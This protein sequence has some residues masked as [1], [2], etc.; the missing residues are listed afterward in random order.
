[1]SSTGT[2][3]IP[4]SEWNKLNKR[5]E[6]IEKALI[7]REPSNEG[8]VRLGKVMQETGLSREVIRGMR[9]THADMVKEVNNRYL[10]NLEAFK[11]TA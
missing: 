1:M 9:K 4:L 3:T 11:K 2:L 6:R 7:P 8:F 10:Y 5:L